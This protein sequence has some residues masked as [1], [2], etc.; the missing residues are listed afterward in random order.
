MD[1][2]DANMR[3]PMDRRGGR[4]RSNNSQTQGQASTVDNVFGTCHA[5]TG[6]DKCV[7]LR[8]VARARARAFWQLWKKQA[9]AFLKLEYFQRLCVFTNDYMM[10][11][12]EEKIANWNVIKKSNKGDVRTW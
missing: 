5:W 2:V 11:L 4:G 1:R 6:A 9:N 3:R 8:Q 12:V 7:E 10:Y